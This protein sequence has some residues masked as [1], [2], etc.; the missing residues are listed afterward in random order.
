MLAGERA[1]PGHRQHEGAQRRDVAHEQDARTR[2]EPCRDRVEELVLAERRPRQRRDDDLRAGA[3]GDLVP[4]DPLGPV[5]VVGQQDLVAAPELDASRHRVEPRRHVRN[6]PEV[7]S[8]RRADVAGDALPDPREPGGKPAG[9]EQHRL[10]LELAPQLVLALED[11]AWHGTEAAVVE[12]RHLGVEHEQLA[13]LLGAR[14]HA[15]SL[16]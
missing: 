4:E 12:V 16:T 3:R 5:L 1:E 2:G 9:E 8:G 14:C 7:V 15:P 13:E 10:E 11:G 6:E